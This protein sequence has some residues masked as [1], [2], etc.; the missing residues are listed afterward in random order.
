MIELKPEFIPLLNIPLTVDNGIVQGWAIP[1]L[2]G[3]CVCKFL[4]QPIT[5]G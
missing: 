5:P 1:V 3:R 2:E 4:F